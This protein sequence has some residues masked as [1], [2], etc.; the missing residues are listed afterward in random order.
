MTIPK[1]WGAGQLFAYSAWDG[2]S[3]GTSDFSGMLSGDRIGIRFNSKVRRELSIVNIKGEE[4][5][6]DAVTGDYICFRSGR[7]DVENIAQCSDHG[8]EASA[9]RVIYARR[10]LIIGNA[11]NGACPIVITEGVHKIDSIE[12]VTIQDTGDGE[13]T[14][15][16]WDGNRFAF[17]FDYSKEAVLALIAEGM[18]LDIE[19]EEA[20]KKAFYEEHSVEESF[21]YAALYG[22]CLSVMKTQLMS[23]EEP[24]TTIWSTPDR[25]PHRHFWLWDSVFHGLGHR[26]IDQALA[27]DLVSAIM[28]SQCED[29]RIPCTTCV[30]KSRTTNHTQPPIIAW[31]AWQ[32]YESGHNKA[33]LEKI[34]EKNGI[35]LEWC[36]DNR[37]MTD[38]ELYTWLTEQDVERCKCGE[39]GMDNSPRFDVNAHLYA[40]DFNCFIAN[41]LRF[42]AKIAAELGDSEKASYYQAWFED[43]KNATNEFLWSEEDGFYFDYNIEEGK[44]HKVWAVSSFL[45]LFAGICDKKQADRLVQ[46]LQDPESFATEF[47]I[48]SISKKDKTFGTDM[49]RGPVWINF[50]YMILQGLKEYGYCDAYQKIRNKTVDNMNRWYQYSGVVFEFYDCN[51]EKPSPRLNRKGTPVEPYDIRLRVQTIRDFGWSCTLLLDLLQDYK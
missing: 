41:D 51:N 34:Y 39:C 23:P 24:F 1:I 26:H 43:V 32:L 9:M 38:K 42:M 46:H 36:R 18:T 5:V 48:P 20:H 21:P 6:F 35:F 11:C 14:A 45:P 40:I 22:K 16:K 15:F 27:E 49:W 44:Q 17:A 47:P 50:N 4:L 28:E 2:P 12:G 29:G 13:Y 25:L 31:G 3:Y 30:D 8:C 10:H 19:V 33:F 7:E 37:R